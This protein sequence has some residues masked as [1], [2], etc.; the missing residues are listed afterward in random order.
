MRVLPPPK[1]NSGDRVIDTLSPSH[2]SADPAKPALSPYP[3]KR[4]SYKHKRFR[5]SLLVLVFLVLTAVLPIPAVFA[6]GDPGIIL[7]SGAITTENKVYF[8]DV[9][10]RIL[11]DGT[12]E[13][14]LDVTQAGKALLIS[15]DIL[16]FNPSVEDAKEDANAWVN[17]SAQKWCTNYY[18]GTA[19]IEKNAILTTTVN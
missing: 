4:S 11:Y 2:G 6:D 19:G 18:D 10:W 14:D 5:T 17:S 16:E 15:N 12:G 3:E 8:G 1:N 9:L 7:G 13:D